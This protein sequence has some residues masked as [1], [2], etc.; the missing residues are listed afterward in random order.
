MM[1]QMCA[2][3][4]VKPAFKWCF[5][6]TFVIKTTVVIHHFKAYEI[7]KKFC[8]YRFAINPT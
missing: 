8:T 3:T 4:N 1:R 2:V 5:L 6:V 7:S